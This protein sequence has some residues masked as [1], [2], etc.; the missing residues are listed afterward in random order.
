MIRYGFAIALSFSVSVCAAP[1]EAQTTF[2][3]S[4]QLLN[5][6]WSDHRVEVYCGC[7]FDATMRV[8]GTCGLPIPLTRKG[9]PNPR[10]RKI[11]FEHVVPAEDFGRQR[12][13]W[14]EVQ[15]DRRGHCEETDPVFAQMHADPRNLL[16]AL[17]LLN[18]YRSNLRYAEISG[19]SRAFGSCDFER[20][21]LGNGE[22]TIEPPN[23][24]KGDVARVY[25][26]FERTYGSSGY[27]VSRQQMQLFLAW[28]KLDPPDAWELE[29]DRRIEKLTGTSNPILK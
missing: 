11:E 8:I 19:E 4:K 21:P 3:A 18:Q 2:R 26:Y 7:S 16:P 5:Q 12:P 25:L 9:E 6:V 23:A 24:L 15:K 13:C 20:N 1:A 28:S 27:R 22:R 14:R 17:G 29:R 10:A